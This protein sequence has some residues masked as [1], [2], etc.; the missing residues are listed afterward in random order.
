MK[1]PLIS[2]IVIVGV[3]VC[4][5]IYLFLPLFF[6][7][8]P[9]HCEHQHIDLNSGRARFTQMRFFLPIS[10]KFEHTPISEAIGITELDVPDGDWMPV[11]TFSPGVTHSP[12]YFFHS[13]FGQAHELDLLWRVSNFTDDARRESAMTVLELW[14]AS[15]RDSGADGFL[16]ELTKMANLAVTA[17]DV[18]AIAKM[19]NKAR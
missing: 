7:W 4:A 2:K 6:P 19:E 17:E 13:A 16:S 1:L 12:H 5:G 3:L 9:I 8:S 18:K 15:G 11:N 14:K 10:Q